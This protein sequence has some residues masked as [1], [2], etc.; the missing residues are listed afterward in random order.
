MISPTHLSGSRHL[1]SFIMTRQIL[2]A[3]RDFAIKSILSWRDNSPS[4]NLDLQNI[5]NEKRY[6]K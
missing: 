1:E 6:T 3:Y 5:D 4:I 2:T